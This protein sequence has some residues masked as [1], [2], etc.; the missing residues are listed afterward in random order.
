MKERTIAFTADW[1]AK[2]KNEGARVEYWDAKLTG[3]TMRVGPKKKVWAYRYRVK[4]DPAMKR[5]DLG[6]YP[7]MSLADAREAAR[8][9]QVEIDK[10]NDPAAQHRADR[11]AETIEWLCGEYIERYAKPNKRTWKTDQQRLELDVIPRWGKRKIHEVKRRDVIALLDAIVDRGSAVQAN[12]VLATIRKMFN[13]ALSRDLLD[14]TPCAQVK[15]PTKESKRPRFCPY[16]Y[17]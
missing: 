8:R 5:R 14:A 16:S 12:R 1:A 9:L 17:S 10:G 13:W 6:T 7:A 11:Q 4:G 2:V 3:L 15:A